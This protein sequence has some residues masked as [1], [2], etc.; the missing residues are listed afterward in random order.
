MVRSISRVFSAGILTVAVLFAG[1]AFAAD[2]DAKELYEHC[3]EQAKRL[4]IDSN[5]MGAFMKT[6][7]GP[8]A[9]ITKLKPSAKYDSE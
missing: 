2:N 1:Q 8:A 7:T 6:C 5:N 3:M 4:N 9:K